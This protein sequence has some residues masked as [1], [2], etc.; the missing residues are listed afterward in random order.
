[1]QNR[2]HFL[3]TAGVTVGLLGTVPSW[4][5]RAAEQ[6]TR[7]K[8]LIT[9]FQRGAAD[10]LNIVVPFSEK[11]YYEIRPTL[12]IAPPKGIAFPV[13]TQAASLAAS[14]ANFAGN[15]NNNLSI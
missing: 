2:R 13:N 10:G 15:T 6:R 1:M 8:I 5:A 12:A 7:R 11:R 14:F 9:V 4:M 3:R